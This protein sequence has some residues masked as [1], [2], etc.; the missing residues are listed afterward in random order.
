MS[1]L[2]HATLNHGMSSARMETLVSR[3]QRW[4]TVQLSLKRPAL[5]ITAKILP[6]NVLG[7]HY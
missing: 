1:S 6:Q 7:L 5:L 2:S 4:I 3:A